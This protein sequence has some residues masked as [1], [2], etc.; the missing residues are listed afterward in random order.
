MRLTKSIRKTLRR[1]QKDARRF[2]KT[3]RRWGK[4]LRRY[5]R[6]FARLRRTVGL[7]KRFS[8]QKKA[9]GL[10]KRFSRQ[11]KALGLQR[12]LNRQQKKTARWRRDVDRRVITIK[13]RGWNQ[14]W[15][16][17]ADRAAAGPTTPRDRI[18]HDLVHGQAQEVRALWRAYG[19][20]S[21]LRSVSATGKTPGPDDDREEQN[22]QVR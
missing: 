17:A 18:L 11:K 19:D 20:P 6:T 9:L 16:L 5:Q 8:R 22:A 10:Q 3:L 7:Q 14:V 15:A 1:R 2:Q 12:R 4:S 13:K 21:A